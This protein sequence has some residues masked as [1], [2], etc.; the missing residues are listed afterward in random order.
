[1]KQLVFILS[2]FVWKNTCIGQTPV[3]NKNQDQRKV[4]FDPQI[5]PSFPAGEGAWGNFIAK[6]LDTG[7][8]AKNGAPSGTYTVNVRFMVGMDSA[9]SNVTCENDPHYGMCQEAIRVVKKSGKW[10]PG[11]QDGRKVNGFKLLPIV[12]TIQ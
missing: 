7:L 2:F 9:V 10:A 4:Y 3:G 5:P 11:K 1:M 8:P 12:F 6:N